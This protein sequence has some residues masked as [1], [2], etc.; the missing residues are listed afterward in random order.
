MKID[1]LTVRMDS[2]IRS[3]RS[4]GLAGLVS[5]CLDRFFKR[6]LDRLAAASGLRLPSVVIRT[7]V[8]KNEFDVSHY[9]L[10]TQR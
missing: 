5:E 7:L 10:D 2:R 8:F 4:E 1:N 9:L 6:F 3:A